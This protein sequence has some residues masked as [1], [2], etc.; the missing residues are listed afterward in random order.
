MNKLLLHI[1]CGPCGIYP[2]RKLQEEGFNMEGFFYNP[3]IHPEEEFDKRRE[4]VYEFSR[5]NSFKVNF[6]DYS[7]ED[8]FDKTGPSMEKNQRCLTCWTLR[9]R[10]T[11]LF[12]RENKF[13]CFTTTLLISPYQD[14]AKIREIGEFIAQEEGINF[15]YRDFREGFRHSQNMAKE[16]GL[17][18]QKYCGCIYSQVERQEE[19]K[20]GRT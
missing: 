8:F 7:P 17:Y 6:N 13:D 19:L 1:C 3:N 9:L 16:M 10:K 18:R 15:F 11:A 12:A 20:A 14:Q 5:K 4:A 2:L